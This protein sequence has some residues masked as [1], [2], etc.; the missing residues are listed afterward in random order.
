MSIG[1]LATAGQKKVTPVTPSSAAPPPAGSIR[2]RNFVLATIIL[3][4][5]FSLPLY[6]L[7]RF[8]AFDKFYSY[9]VLIP[10]ISVY[11]ARL[12]KSDLSPHS[13][14]ARKLAALFLAGGLA[15]MAGYWLAVYSHARLAD[16]DY[17]AMTTLAFLLFFASGG[18][19]FLGGKNMRALAFA[20]GFL[21]F[22]IPLPA[23]LRHA[24]E[25]SL[26]NGS[27]AVAE[28]FFVLS[29][30]LYFRDGLVFQL[31][32]ISLEVAPECSGIH[33]SM[34]L[35]ITSVLAGY[36]FLR[37]PW[38]R[39]ALALFVIP[40]A[41]VRN[42]FRIFVLGELCVHIGPQMI[43][44]PIHHRGGP[45]FFILSLIP[46]FLLLVY[47]RKSEQPNHARPAGTPG[48]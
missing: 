6:D 48:T 36:L 25:T 10:F 7:M 34:A 19:L 3:A 4:L 23:L 15:V 17:L 40:L 45:L 32:D 26:Q 22:M 38:K 13:E 20:I 18:C 42:G 41:I 8:A 24:I 39:V 46:F 37:R 1:K 30:T 31:S 29:H 43:N 21:V 16:V 11:L 2:L 28:W 27:A 33:S 14:P 5:C 35:L 47:L 12:K 9:I 44:S